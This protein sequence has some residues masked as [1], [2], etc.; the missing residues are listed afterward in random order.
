MATAAKSKK[1][2]KVRKVRKVLDGVAHV[3]ASFNNTIITIS[4]RVGNPL[5]CS[6]S[7]ACGFK[8]SRKSTPYAA[9]MAGEKASEAA[10]AYGLKSVAIVIKGAGPGREPAI[11]ALGKFFAISEILDKTG[12]P[13][14]G[15]RD[16]GERR[17]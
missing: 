13:H 16:A 15:C 1:K 14:N 6:S 4:D 10:Q 2:D 9:Q 7:G 17:I 8:G 3:R 5:C 12:V 11:K